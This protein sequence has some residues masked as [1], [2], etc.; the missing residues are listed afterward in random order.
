MEKYLKSTASIDS[1]NE[2]VREM[3]DCLTLDIKDDVEK[4]YKL[5]YFARD[6]IRY[7]PY[8]ALY[9][10]EASGILS[11]RYGFC[12]QKAVLLAALAR[13]VGIPARLGFVDILNHQLH[14]EWRRIFGTDI[15]VYHGFAELYLHGT[16][17]KATPAFDLRM[18][19]ENGFIPVEFDGMNHAML[20]AHNVYGEPHI[21][22]LEAHGAYE[23]LPLVEIITAVYKA[24]GDKFLECWKSG[25]WDYYTSSV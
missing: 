3:A 5:F 13:S 12:V 6:E 24:Y 11:Q 9:P 7:N 22:Y 21:E 17:L 20:P 8:S 18:C 25:Q 15:V 4:A 14:P 23:D 1:D 16:W 19:L 10:V 2:R